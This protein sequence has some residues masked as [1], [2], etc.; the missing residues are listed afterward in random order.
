MNKLLLTTACAMALMLSACSKPP[1]PPPGPPGAKGDAGAPGPKGDKGDR[2]DAG[3]K[4][5]TGQKGDAGPKGDKGDKGDAG[6][7]GTAGAPGAPGAAGAAGA[8]FRVVTSASASAN[9][10]GDEVVISAICTGSPNFTPLKLTDNGGQCGDEP[11]AT[12][13]QI[14]LV[15]GKK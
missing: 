9:C 5:D 4:G 2:G 10:N 8:S 15:C 11:N 6:A 1:P 3:A 13:V 12:A 7:A 14:R